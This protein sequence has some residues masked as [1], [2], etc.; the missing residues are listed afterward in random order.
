MNKQINA[1]ETNQSVMS[2]ILSQKSAKTDEEGD[3]YLCLLMNQPSHLA[4][5]SGKAVSIRK[6]DVTI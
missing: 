4:V 3:H 1:R 5:T 2:P 6:S